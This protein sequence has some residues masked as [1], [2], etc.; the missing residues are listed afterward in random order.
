MNKRWQSLVG[1]VLVGLAAGLAGGCE[2]DDPFDG[3]NW[4][5]SNQ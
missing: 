1:V 5:F 3:D 4:K 2:D